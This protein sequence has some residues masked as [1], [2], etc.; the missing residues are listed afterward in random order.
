MQSIFHGLKYKIQRLKFTFHG[1]KYRF[2]I[3]IYRLRSKNE[4]FKRRLKS[5]LL[6]WKMV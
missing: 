5:L 1:V 4:L 6:G 2:Q 3:W